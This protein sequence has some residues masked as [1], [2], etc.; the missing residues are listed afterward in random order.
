MRSAGRNRVQAMPGSRATGLRTGV[1]I[2]GSQ[3]AGTVHRTRAPT[4]AILTTITSGKAG[5][6]MRGIGTTRTTTGTIA[7][8]TTRI[9]GRITITIAITRRG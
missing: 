6:C 5:N 7:T 9:M 2:G 4:G 8:K 3:A 1:T